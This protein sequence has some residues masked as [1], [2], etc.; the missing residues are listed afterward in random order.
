MEWGH[1]ESFVWLW[2]A[3]A[4]LV[5]FLLSAWR[6]KTQIKRFGDPVLIERLITSFSPAKRFVKRALLMA[7]LAL[8]VLSLCQ[9]HFRAREVTVER[10]GVDVMIAVDVSN[11]MLAKDIAPNRLE[12]AKL[13]LATLI[14]KLKQDRIGIVAF[15]GEAFIQ[16]PLTLDRGAVKLFLSTLNPNL[17][18]T[19]GTMIGP[20]LRVS[21]Q[22]FS[23]NDKES[24]AII[25]LTDG[26]DQ[27]S[28]PLEMVRKAKDAGIPIYTIGIGTTDGSVLPSENTRDSFKMDRKGQVVLSKL[29]ENLLK[30]ISKDT[31]GV[32]YRSSRG[33]VEVDKLVSEIRKMGQKGLKSDKII[34]YDENYQYFLLPAFLLLCLEWLLSERRRNHAVFNN[35]VNLTQRKNDKKPARKT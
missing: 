8:I 27:G 5:A 11:S 21:M 1:P 3:A 4:A 28:N 33:E 24:K 15:A 12:K 29:D 14:E 19:P 23:E 18:P 20:A 6:R 35:V 25:L 2:T 26:E 17:I 22:A 31:G 9:P 10:R 16:C 34:E 32:Y 13:E 7:V 30:R